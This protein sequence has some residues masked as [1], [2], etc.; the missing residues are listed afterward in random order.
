L[1]NR[2]TN[3]IVGE[4][5]VVELEKKG[6]CAVLDALVDFTFPEG[7][8]ASTEKFTKMLTKDPKEEK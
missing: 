4:E 1:F 2:A 8:P 3:G 5:L 7:E 6:G